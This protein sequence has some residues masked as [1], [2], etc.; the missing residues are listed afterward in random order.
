[1]HESLY[2]SRALNLAERAIE[3]SEIDEKLFLKPS[4]KVSIILGMVKRGEWEADIVD[5]TSLRLFLFLVVWV[6]YIQTYH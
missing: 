5:G 2:D 3:S 4:S 1:M 6:E